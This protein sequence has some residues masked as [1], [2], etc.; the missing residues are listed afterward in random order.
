VTVNVI[1]YMQFNNTI[2]INASRRAVTDFT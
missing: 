2:S 1:V